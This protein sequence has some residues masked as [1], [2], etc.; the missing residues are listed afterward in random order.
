MDPTVSRTE[1]A[2]QVTDTAVIEP[3]ASQA[4]TPSPYASGAA[5]AAPAAPVAQ[6]SVRSTYVASNGPVGFRPRQLLWLAYAIVAG[7]LVVDLVFHAAGASTG[8]SFVNF[9][10]NVGGA[11]NMP[12]RNIIAGQQP[13]VATLQ[14]A[15]VIA[16]VVY[17]FAAWVVE[18]VIVIMSR[19]SQPSTV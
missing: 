9:V 4:P 8:S 18:R 2:T 1:Y 3:A 17:A 15:D 6:R 12:F 5:V 13:G 11:F 16:L 7:F 10:Y 14:W 19:S